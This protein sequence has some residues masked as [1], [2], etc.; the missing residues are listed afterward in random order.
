MTSLKPLGIAL[1]SPNDIGPLA[2]RVGVTAAEAAAVK[3]HASREESR[4]DHISALETWRVATWLTPADARAWEAV[5][6][7]LHALGRDA[8]SLAV[9]RAAEVVAGVTS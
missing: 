2:L 3:R 7:C 9:A 6:R 4:G 5:A 8:E 1:P